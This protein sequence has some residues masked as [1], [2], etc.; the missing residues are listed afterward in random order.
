[1]SHGKDF[2]MELV[3]THA[4]SL[5]N[6]AE[7]KIGDP[8][9]AEDLV[10]ETLLVAW[11]DI[12]DLQSHPLP[13]GWLYVTLSNIITRELARKYREMELLSPI[14]STLPS[15]VSASP[16]FEIIPPDLSRDDVQLLIWRFQDCLDFTEIG[17]NLGISTDAAKQRVYRAIKACRAQLAE[18]E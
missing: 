3:N 14:I 17:L 10:M 11:Q 7:R 15:E 4:E 6:F 12:N 2:F 5:V 8:Y 1:M 18:K 9:L 16:L 13:I